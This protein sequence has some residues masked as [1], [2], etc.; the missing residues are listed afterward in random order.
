MDKWLSV[1]EF[2]MISHSGELWLHLK[3]LQIKCIAYNKK[4]VT[5]QQTTCFMCNFAHILY[6]SR[7]I[8]AQSMMQQGTAGVSLS[9]QIV[10]EL[11]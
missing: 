10:L 7:A 9:S 5:P 2:E 8:G 11:S 6:M 1:R 4:L 3:T